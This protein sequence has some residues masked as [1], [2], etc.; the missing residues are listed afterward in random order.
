MTYLIVA[1]IIVACIAVVCLFASMELARH[2]KLIEARLNMTPA[3]VDAPISAFAGRTLSEIMPQAPPPVRGATSGVFV[4]LSATCA[5]CT[6]IGRQAR[7]HGLLARPGVLAVL[8][9]PPYDA[10]RLVGEIFPETEQTSAEYVLDTTLSVA[11]GLGFTQRPAVLVVDHQQITRLAVVRNL[12]ELLAVV[13][14]QPAG[15]SMRERTGF[16]RAR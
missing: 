4:L 8:E 14:E 5:T 9:A 7:E 10:D 16:G 2:I 15:D 13:G 12:E 11:D 6:V 1:Q 3:P